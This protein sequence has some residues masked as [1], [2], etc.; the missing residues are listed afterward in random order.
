M[1]RRSPLDTIN[2]DKIGDESGVAVSYPSLAEDLNPGD[3]L[4]LDDGLISMHVEQVDGGMVHCVVETGGCLR[5]RKGL[6]V[7]GGGLSVSGIT[8]KDIQDIQIARE[9]GVDFVAVSFV[10]DGDDV[11]KARN[12]LREAGSQAGVLAKIERSEAID[13]LEEICNTAAGVMVARG[14]LG[15][16]IGDAALPGI[17]KR[18][19]DTAIEHNVLAITATPDD[20]IHGGKPDSDPCRGAGRGECGDRWYRCGDAFRGNRGW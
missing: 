19:I 2:T 14:D 15:V 1:A 3:L 5:D 13:N 4:L 6:N 8:E 17:Q 20:G 9:M 18:I 16:E 12:L 7:R 10:T 11:K